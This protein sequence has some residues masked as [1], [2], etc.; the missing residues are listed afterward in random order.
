MKVW[1]MA[2]SIVIVITPS[3]STDG[4]PVPAEFDARLED[5]QQVLV[6]SRQPLLDAARKLIALG[7]HPATVLFM[8]HDDADHASLRATI[9]VAAALTVDEEK[10][11]GPRLKRWKPFPSGAAGA[12]TPR[13]GNTPSAN[14]IFAKAA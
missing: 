13:N 10:S 12:K 11:R 2:Q 9:R 14:P 1:A 7:Y 8:R 4:E 6:T 3:R 5:A